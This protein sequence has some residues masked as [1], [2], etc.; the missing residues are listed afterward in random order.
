MSRQS[1]ERQ[2]RERLAQAAAQILADSGTRDFY[3]AKRK[4]AEQLGAVDTRNMPSNSEIETALMT[5]QRLFRGEA[6]A[7]E[8]QRLREVALRAMKFFAA[9][10]PR[11]VGSVLRGTADAHSPVTLHVRADTVEELNLFLLR[12]AIPFETADK[13]LRFGTETYQTLPLLRFVAEDTPVEVVVFPEQ[14]PHQPPLSPVDGRPMQR[15]DMQKVEA[16]LAQGR[17]EGKPL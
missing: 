11:L 1:K 12:H 15:A 17:A 14:A 10:R 8:L 16:L 9:F 7:R 4:A 5:Y 3:V 6:Q 2:M 13:R